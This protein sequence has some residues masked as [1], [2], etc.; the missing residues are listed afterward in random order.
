MTDRMSPHGHRIGRPRSENIAKRFT[1]AFSI[2]D[3]IA[4]N[5]QAV[6]EDRS[7]TWVVRRA[8]AEYLRAH[9]KLEE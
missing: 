2:D 6:F 9:R 4:L 7:M 1:I 5:N 3:Y 8:V